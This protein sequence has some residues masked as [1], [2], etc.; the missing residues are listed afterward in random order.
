MSTEYARLYYVQLKAQLTTLVPLALIFFSPPAVILF[1]YTNTALGGSFEALAAYL[2]EE[3]LLKG[4]LSIWA[5][6]FFGSAVAWKILV[7]FAALQLLFMKVLPGPYYHG[8]ITPKGNIP[9]Y[10][11]NGLVAFA[12]TLLLFYLAA[13]QWG[14]FSPTIIYDNFGPL[15]GAINLFSLFFC[16]LLYIKGRYYPSSSDAGTSG[17]FIFDYYWGTELYPRLC[18]W[19]VKMFTNC[20]FGMMSW[21]L[22]IIS[23]AAKQYE[24]YGFLSDSMAVAVALQLLYIAKF[25]L[26]ETGYLS[27]LDIMHDRAGYYICWGCLVWLPG[28]YTSPTMYLVDH[29]NQLGIVWSLA[30]FIAGVLSISINYWA[31]RQRQR[32]RASQGQC[33]VWGRP[34]LITAATYRT[35]QGELKQNLLLASGWW[36]IS[37]HFHYLPEILGAFLW[38]VPALFNDFLPYFYVLFLTTILLERAFRDDKR[39]A[40]KYGSAWDDYC[41][42]VPYKILPYVI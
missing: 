41:R 6:L 33:T 4:I 9:I 1:W 15:L 38:S 29:P 13:F 34:P 22:I 28:I 5:P 19:D 20:R 30:I 27:S 26:W 18:G 36:G 16:L 8:P 17:N 31:D 7:V 14:L 32:V 3:G 21:G 11:A 37:R 2:S 39:C 24:H 23:F 42:R 12:T 35:E 10:K 40:D 25:F